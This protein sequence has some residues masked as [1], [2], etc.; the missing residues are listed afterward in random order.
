MTIP[1]G[2]P[3]ALGAT[4][5]PNSARFDRI[6]LAASFRPSTAAVGITSGFLIGAPNTQGEST[7]V[8]DTLL[9]LQPFTAIVQ[10]THN[11]QQ[12]QYVVPNGTQ[13]DLT[14]P[15]KD[16]SL[17]RR[18]LVVVRVADSLEAGVASSATTDGAFLEVL[19]GTLAASNPALPATPANALLVGELSVPSVASGQPVT[20][21]PYNPRTGVRG[22]ILPVYNDAI[23]RTGHG[24]APGLFTGEYRDHPT[25]GLQRW[26]GTEWVHGGGG[27][28]PPVVP[29]TIPAGWTPNG[30]QIPAVYKDASGL[31]HLVGIIHNTNAYGPQSSGGS[32]ICAVIP[33]GYRPAV[34]HAAVLTTGGNGPLLTVGIHANGN[35]VIDGAPSNV[36]VGA[37][38][39][40]WLSSIPP[41]HTG[42]P[43][44]PLPWN[45]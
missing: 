8:S 37:N 10:G 17:F 7:L 42:Y 6:A 11:S 22:G 41:W 29:I 4:G 21:T 43:G 39:G 32:Y 14:V 9:R 26:T 38:F 44:N 3:F 5:V 25:R 34:N 31:V 27:S 45:P 13:R 15:T 20:W 16:A 33:V 40:H 36:V 28:L 18:A 2:N 12:G 24:G 19:S 23:D 30:G 1:L 35:V